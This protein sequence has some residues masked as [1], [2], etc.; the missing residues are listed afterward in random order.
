MQKP[1]QSPL[2]LR[3]AGVNSA[4]FQDRTVVGL[5]APDE[6]SLSLFS[7]PSHSLSQQIC[8]SSCCSI[9]LGRIWDL[10]GK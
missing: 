4:L 9:E 5:Q 1:E 7:L 10:A 8:S 3:R 2:R 6:D